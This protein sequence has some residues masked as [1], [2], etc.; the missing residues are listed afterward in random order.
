M[1]NPHAIAR[2][3]FP[4][5]VG[6]VSPRLPRADLAAERARAVRGRDRHHPRRPGAGDDR[7]ARARRAHDRYR[8]RRSYDHQA[9]GE[10]RLL[11]ASV[12]RRRC[13]RRRHGE[14]A[15]DR[16]RPRRHR[17]DRARGARPL[18]DAHFATVYAKPMGKPLVDTFITEVS[19][20]T[21]I[22]FP[23]DTALAFQP[24]IRAGR[25]NRHCEDARSATRQ[26]SCARQRAMMHVTAAVARLQRGCRRAA[27]CFASLAMTAFTPTSA[28]PA[29]P[30]RPAPSASPRRSRAASAPCRS[31]WWR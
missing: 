1:T 3:G 8:L 18:P 5:L 11:K 4:G 30:L 9:Q 6:A 20:D 29:S 17:Q 10:L 16:R 28:S 26:S 14:G 24:P 22:H 19:Q 31:W 15:L 27:G 25:R 21:W 2:K 12:G 23:W 13:A 7:R